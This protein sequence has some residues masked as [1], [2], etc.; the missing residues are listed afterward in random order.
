MFK[1]NVRRVTPWFLF[2]ALFIS[3]CGGA[4]KNAALDSIPKESAAPD[5]ILTDNAAS[6]T[7]PMETDLSASTGSEIISS[8]PES[9]LAEHGVV[10]PSGSKSGSEI[11]FETND[12]AKTQNTSKT[13]YMI[14]GNDSPLVPCLTLS[15]DGKFTFSYDLLSSYLTYGTYTINE[16]RLTARTDDG[17]YHFVFTADKGQLIFLQE[18]SSKVSLIDNKIGIPVSD[19]AVFAAKEPDIKGQVQMIGVVKEIQDGCLL[20]SSVSDQFPGVFYVHFGSLDISGI[21]G[22]DKIRVTWNGNIEETNPAQ[23]H[24]DMIDIPFEPDFAG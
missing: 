4:A 21:K 24:A 13:Y 23:I 2:L 6:N 19:G 15:D 18:E 5:V 10:R 3:G 9:S 7:V 20:V 1:R 17:R 12:Y 8:A 16:G 22:G 14:T 11:T